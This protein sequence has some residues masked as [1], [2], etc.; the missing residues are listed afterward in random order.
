MMWLARKTGESTGGSKTRTRAALP[1]A[2][3]GA[4]SKTVGVG[5]AL[6]GVLGG[7]GAV[8]SLATGEGRAAAGPS[9]P[10]GVDAGMGPPSAFVVRVRRGEVAVPSLD[11]VERMCALLTSCD[12]LPI[13]SAVFPPD[14]SDCVAKMSEEMSSP[15]AVNFSLTVRECGLHADSCASLR[16][17]AL[18]GASLEACKGRGRQGVVGFCDVDGRAM[19][20]WH[21][22]VLSVRDCPRGSEQCIV[23]DGEATCTLGACQA[24]GKSPGGGDRPSCSASGTHLLRCEKGKLAS[25]DCT[26]FGLK[27]ATGADGVAGCATSGPSCAGA[28]R[29]C[30]GRVAVGCYNGHQVRVDC[31]SAGLSCAASPGAATVGACAAPAPPAGGGCDPGEKPRCDGDDIRYCH[32][33]RPRAFS[34]RALGFHKCDARDSG[35]RCSL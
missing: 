34:C 18:H 31:D 2:P 24:G 13:P 6:L 15:S 12:R 16:V 26:A 14:F 30:D 22:E 1:G 17:C 32:A 8:G 7:L 11:D 27:C 20:C 35:V 21:D 25:L 9:A 5:T 23:V 28:A 4:G 19:T 29:R 10:S 3:S 33:G